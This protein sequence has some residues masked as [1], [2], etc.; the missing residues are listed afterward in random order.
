MTRLADPGGDGWPTG[1]AAWLAAVAFTACAL[2]VLVVGARW[3]CPEGVCGVPWPDRAALEVF[4]RL[5]SPMLDIG[6][7]A[8]TWLGSLVVLGPAALVLA[9]R[10]RAAGRSVRASVFVPLALVGAALGSRL[11]KLAVGR[12]RPDEFVLL[13]AMPVDASYPSAHVMQAVAFALAWQ[14]RPGRAP[15]AREAV[16][17]AARV[18]GVALSRMYLQVHFPSDVLAGGV[19]AVFWVLALRCLPVWG[20]P[21]R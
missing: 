15:R 16:A 18:A 20:R 10:Q 7:G 21:G 1:A 14:L 19:A 13:G 8:L 9:G 17:A 6:F 5:R 4:D 2:L 11:A 3:I 12:P